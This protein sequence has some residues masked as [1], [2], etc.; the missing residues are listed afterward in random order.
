M[1]LKEVL[2]QKSAFRKLQARSRRL[3]KEYQ[4]VY[5]EMQK[6]C[7]HSGALVEHQMIGVFED[8]LTFFEEGASEGRGIKDIIGTDVAVFCDAVIDAQR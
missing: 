5:R 8:I 6:Y 3:P 4:M 1:R 2:E 7:Y